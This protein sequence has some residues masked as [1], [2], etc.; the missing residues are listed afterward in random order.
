MGKSGKS[1][2][3]LV[4]QAER[5]TDAKTLCDIGWAL[6][7]ADADSAAGA[8]FTRVLAV[9]PRHG[10]ALQGLARVQEAAGQLDDAVETLRRAIRWSPDGA[11]LRADAVNLEL[12]RDAPQSAIE[13]LAVLM[14]KDAEEVEER[15]TAN[16]YDDLDAILARFFQRCTRV[17]PDKSALVVFSRGIVRFLRNRPEWNHPT[18]RESLID[19]AVDVGAMATTKTP[20]V[21]ATLSLAWALLEH[22]E[23]RSEVAEL[24]EGIEHPEASYL[25][26]CALARQGGKDG[27][28]RARSE[29][30]TAAAAGV[31]DAAYELGAMLRSDDPER[32]REMLEAAGRAGYSPACF[33]LGKR[34]GD[35]G[36]D[37]EVAVSWLERAAWLGYGEAAELLSKAYAA[38][39]VVDQDEELAADWLRVARAEINFHWSVEA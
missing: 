29:L 23:R 5:T 11:L 36:E 17:D 25:R 16:G 6:L 4:S 9:R 15:L 31:A 7:D 20:G 28:A 30:V 2:R 8:A 35:G 10:D 34:L 26:A 21:E 33:E 38:G 39:E 14:A 22:P 12:Q 32:A 27:A 24:V 19:E 3:T 18:A 37:P 1:V 13:H